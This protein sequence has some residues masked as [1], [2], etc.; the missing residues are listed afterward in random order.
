ML[1]D[2]S[3]NL[4][5]C[6]TVLRR[7]YPNHQVKSL[8]PLSRQELC[9]LLGQPGE[10]ETIDVLPSPSLSTLEK[11]LGFEQMPTEESE[12]DEER[13]DRDPIPAE[14][15]DINALSLTMD[16]TTSYLG[17]SSVKAALMVMLKVEP[18]LRAALASPPKA[19]GE[20]PSGGPVFCHLVKPPKENSPIAW[21][22]KGQTFV[23]AYFKR[24]HIFT[25]MLDEV[26]LRADYLKGQRQDAPWLSLLNMVF[27]MGNI[28]ATTS[29]DLNHV[30]YYN[31]AMEHLH[32]SAFG[33][34]HIETVQALILLGG[35]YLHYINRPN[36]ANAILGAAIRMASALGLHRE[37]LTQKS[38]GVAVAETRR[39]TWWSLFCLDTW[40]TTT[41]GRPSFGRW[42]PAINIQP[43]KLIT[44]EE[45][46][47]SAQHAGIMPLLENIKFCKIAT[48]IQDVL[49]LSPLLNKEDRGHLDGLLV[50]WY[51]TLPWLLQTTEPC[52]EPLSLSRCVMK[53]RYWNLRIL[54]YRHTLLTL[55][56]NSKGLTMTE[57][58]VSAIETCQELAKA[59]IDDIKTEWMRHQ[60]SGW[61]AVW[62]LYQAVMI[63]LVSILWQPKSPSLP[64][65]QSQVETALGLFDAMEDWSLTARRSRDVVCQIYNASCRFS[66]HDSSPPQ[67][68]QGEQGQMVESIHASPIGLETDDV[69]NML[70]QDWL[71]DVDGLFW[72]QQSLLPVEDDIF[73]VESDM[74]A[75]DYL[76]LDRDGAYANME[77]M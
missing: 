61:N 24:L 12:W 56:S 53:W 41:M 39:R 76:S 18:R 5:E 26:T 38:G 32:L 25:P 1:E 77:S 7:L 74:M 29:S 71:W 64:E 57:H 43:P 73:G 50:D 21:T 3:Q 6:R 45:D 14:A 9:N 72:E 67:G 54:L 69:V 52:A 28:M 58:D 11:P 47:D 20:K 17:A 27:A 8:L 15:D 36:M 16:R 4:E 62:F 49:A 37:S 70:D 48:Q 2:L 31:Q 22:W 42:G 55:A 46:H 44:N 19:P 34:S 35:H 13:R 23:D 59:T 51:N 40:T 63:P 60:M 33:S 65:W 75:G 68:G 10:A 30:K 66:S